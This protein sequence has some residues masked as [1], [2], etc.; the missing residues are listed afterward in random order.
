MGTGKR[1]GWYMKEMEEYIK[2]MKQFGDLANHVLEALQDLFSSDPENIKQD[3]ATLK[4]DLPELENLASKFKGE[5]TK[6]MEAHYA[7]PYLKNTKHKSKNGPVSFPGWTKKIRQDIHHL[8]PKGSEKDLWLAVISKGL[9]AWMKGKNFS[10]MEL[11]S[12]S[13]RRASI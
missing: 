4:K 5:L 3:L 11:E 13:N 8:Y 10:T 7:L 1:F 2:A 9:L 6:M 12:L